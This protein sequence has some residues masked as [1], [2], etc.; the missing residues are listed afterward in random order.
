MLPSL[1]LER[2]GRPF[3]QLVERSRSPIPASPTLSFALRP[4]PLVEPLRFLISPRR[5][6]LRKAQALRLL[7]VRSRLTL[8]RLT[9]RRRRRIRLPNY[10]PSL[11]LSPIRR[12]ERRRL[13]FLTSLPMRTHWP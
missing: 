7:A 3:N 2:S 6:Q 4:F 12:T 10:P 9:E 8:E 5:L 13:A 1:L 11:A